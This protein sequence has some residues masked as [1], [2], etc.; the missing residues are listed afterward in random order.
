MADS[1]LSEMAPSTG[2]AVRRKHRRARVAQPAG[3]GRI[4]A[5]AGQKNRHPLFESQ[6][7]GAGAHIALQ[8]TVAGQA[9]PPLEMLHQFR[10]AHHM[11]HI[12]LAVG[13]RHAETRALEQA[14]KRIDLRSGQIEKFL[15]PL[16]ALVQSGFGQTADSGAP[17]RQGSTP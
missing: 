17:S 9:A 13:Q 7:N 3:L 1:P 4:H 14:V 5:L 8:P 15:L 12:A 10:I 6:T 16:D 11:Q 2:P